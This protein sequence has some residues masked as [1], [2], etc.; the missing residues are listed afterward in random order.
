ME[1]NHVKLDLHDYKFFNYEKLLAKMEVE[2]FLKKK[3][4]EENESNFIIS[5][6]VKPEELKRLTYFSKATQG[7]KELVSAQ[8]HLE[9]VT[10][11]K[12]QSTRYS[13]HGLHEYKGKFNPQ[14]VRAI[15]NIYNIESNSNVLDPFCGSGTTLLESKYIGMNTFGID[16]NPLAVFI[17]QTK[18]SS[19]DYNL[20]LLT[21]F[22][23]KFMSE[24]NVTKLNIDHTS[25]RFLYLEKWFPNEVLVKIEKMKNYLDSS[26]SK[27]KDLI[28]ILISDV[29]KRFSYQDEADLRIRRRKD[30]VTNFNIE[31]A[32][33]T[34]FDKFLAELGNFKTIYKK[35]NNSNSIIKGNISLSELSITEDW[36]NKFDAAITS[37]PYATALPY[38]DTQR[39]SL[40]WIGL[41]TPQELRATEAAL[42]GSREFTNDKKIWEKKLSSNE[43]NLPD[44]SYAFCLRLKN[45]LSEADGFRRQ[46][47]PTL[48]YKYLAEMQQMFINVN[49][50]LKTDAPFCLVVGH[51]QTT[52]GGT[53]ID[54]NTPQLLIDLALNTGFSLDKLIPLDVYKRFG[55]NYKNAVNI[56][57]LI[58][59]RKNGR[60]RNTSKRL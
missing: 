24:F 4:I 17:A 14:I 49:K 37:P 55:L 22:F 47:V 42:I 13:A 25:E 26:N 28:F 39:L 48:I 54:I 41:L 31:E 38:I 43:H 6:S 35:T 12:R 53:K 58:V 56:E 29:I 19:V 40:V 46:A 7:G 27:Y 45:S 50:M 32:I 57:D 33:H 59:L 51:N 9:S 1:K 36:K 5:G 2:N 52:L 23:E 44:D 30:P 3:I 11:A 60:I 15:L 34:K 18:L 10:K 21:E 20:N 16:I 8:S